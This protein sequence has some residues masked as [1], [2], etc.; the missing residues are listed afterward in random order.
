MNRNPLRHLNRR[1]EEIH[2]ELLEIVEEQEAEETIIGGESF[3]HTKW[4]LAEA[5]AID[6]KRKKA[7]TPEGDLAEA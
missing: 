5:D 4:L 7:M 3:D 1:E 2:K 6:Y